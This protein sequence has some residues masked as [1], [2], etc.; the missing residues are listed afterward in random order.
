M[1]ESRD[2][3]VSD[4]QAQL[5]LHSL[6]ALFGTFAEIENDKARNK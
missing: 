1:A 3:V 5:D 2:H 4:E 6:G